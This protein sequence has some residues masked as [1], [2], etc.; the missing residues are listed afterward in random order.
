MQRNDTTSLIYED[1]HL[2]LEGLDGKKRKAKKAAK[3]NKRKAKKAK[4]KKRRRKIWGFLKRF[5]PALSAIRNGLYAA[6]KIDMK[7]MSSRLRY[8]YLSP[9]EAQ[10]LGVDLNKLGKI[11]KTLTKLERTV[12]KLGGKK[13]NLKKAILK[14]R[15]NKDRK[16]PLNGVVPYLSEFDSYENEVNGLGEVATATVIAA[17]TPIILATLNMMKKSGVDTEEE[18]YDSSQTD[19][20]PDEEELPEE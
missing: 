2:D 14:G 8:G 19:Y 4:R 11:K 3:K 7:K 16:V 18:M 5:N 17:A 9:Q 1:D 6:A 15:G 20:D 13:K 12:E 10:K